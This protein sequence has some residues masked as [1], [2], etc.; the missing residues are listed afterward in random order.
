MIVLNGSGKLEQILSYI[1]TVLAIICLSALIFFLY[2]VNTDMYI[3]VVGTIAALLIVVIWLLFE[4]RRTRPMRVINMDYESSIKR[5][6]LMTRDGDKEKEW[7]CEGVSSF[8][9]GKSTIAGEVDMELGDTHYCEFISN[10][11]AVLNYS[12]GHWYIE[13][14]DS[15]N[16]VGIKKRGE[17]YALRLKP[18]TSY[19]IDEGDIIY[20]SKAKI[21]VR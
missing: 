13:D 9:I 4:Y 2:F 17:E 14:L 7:H 8:L 18:L 16:G 11:H 6:V 21:L 1:A 12:D 10:E 20:I 15:R 5:F 3:R 19:K